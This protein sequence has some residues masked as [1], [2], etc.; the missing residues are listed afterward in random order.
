[1]DAVSGSNGTDGRQEGV[2]ISLQALRAD[3]ARVRAW[4]VKYG[5]WTR[6]ESDEVGAAIAA[7]AKADEAG[8][9]RFWGEWMARYAECA[10][11]HEA[12]MVALDVA[13]ARW[14]ADQQRRAA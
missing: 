1:M 7:A 11:A 4:M 2:A 9:L 10:L 8:E 5:E 6:S 13:A 14:W 3:F 12:Q